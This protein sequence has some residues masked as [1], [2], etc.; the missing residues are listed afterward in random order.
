MAG[1]IPE[2]QRRRL[3]SARVGTAGVDLSTAR[4]ISSVAGAVKKV[5]AKQ[6]KAEAKQSALRKQAL[7]D[8]RTAIR[9]SKFATKVSSIRSAST[10]PE[11][12]NTKIGELLESDVAGI[13][14][15]TERAAFSRFASNHVLSQSLR[16]NKH[17]RDRELGEIE[18]NINI[19]AETN[20]MFLSDTFG[21]VG[22]SLTDIPLSSAIEDFDEVNKLHDAQLDTF[23]QALGLQKVQELKQNDRAMNARGA[24][25][26]LVDSSPRDV[27]E[28]INRAVKDLLP[29]DE[30]QE[31]REYAT[32]VAV[33]REKQKKALRIRTQNDT[34]ETWANRLAAGDVPTEAEM[35]TA[36]LNNEVTEADITAVRKW[37]ASDKKVFLGDNAKAYAGLVTEFGAI[38]PETQKRADKQLKEDMQN[39]TFE[40]VALFRQRVLESMAEGEISQGTGQKWLTRITPRFNE[41][42]DGL[43]NSINTVVTAE[44]WW[45]D[46]TEQILTDPNEVIEANMRMQNQLMQEIDNQE[47]KLDRRLRFDE[48]KTITDDIK[49]NFTFRTNQDRGTYKLGEIRQLSGRLYRVTGYDLDGEPILNDDLNASVS[50]APKK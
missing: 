26:A 23:T 38:G 43:L 9:G 34:G 12:F 46:S 20:A 3:Q 19:N 47:N 33:A 48:I 28:F 45:S 13:E 44:G 14:D 49:T 31:I 29:P 41:G 1:I 24:V 7:T 16:A 35:A 8:S 10:D 18:N 39:I 4:A 21:L 17:F 32:R 5:E 11:D 30:V 50:E 27:E 40:Q 37:K 25:S 2:G 15:D 6:A 22:V 42:V 36:K